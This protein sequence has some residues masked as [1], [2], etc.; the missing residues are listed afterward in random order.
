MI[1]FDFE[2]YVK[3]IN[4]A[5]PRR[6]INPLDTKA[7]TVVCI[8]WLQGLCQKMENCEF[9]HKLDKSKMPLCKHGSQ[10]R[11]KNCPKKHE[12]DEEKEECPFFL[13]GFC[14]HGPY[15]KYKH[16]KRPPDDCPDEVN[17]LELMNSNKKRKASAP[18]LSYKISICKHW[19]EGSTCP[20]GDG[21]IFAHGEEDLKSASFHDD[22]D[23][24]GIYDPVGTK[25]NT[26]GD[27][28]VYTA[29]NTAYFVLQAPDLVSLARAMKR[30]VWSANAAAVR[31]LSVAKDKFEHVLMFFNVGSLYAI[32]A[33][34]ELDARGVPIPPPASPTSLSVPFPVVWLRSYRLSVRTTYQL[35]LAQGMHLGKLE[36]D[37]RL[38]G[39][40]GYVRIY[41]YDIMLL[42]FINYLCE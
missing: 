23:D 29:T 35:R 4:D 40:V 2:N 24:A 26:V 13:Q 27:K 9:L 17:F 15:C 28:P 8:H 30:G 25:M 12:S 37:G 36:A 16:I 32:Y 1:D 20:F 14:M 19:L 6:K 39:T 21:C 3:S 5:K 10:C 31:E 42:N 22:I 33:T 41:A 7:H 11:K 34:A 18:N 38:D